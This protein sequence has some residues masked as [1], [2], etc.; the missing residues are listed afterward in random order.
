MKKRVGEETKQRISKSK[1]CR[2]CYALALYFLILSFFLTACN[3]TPPSSSSN[4]VFIKVAGS[5][6]MRPLLVQLTNA[7]SADHPNIRFDVQG[8]GSQLGQQLVE[9]GQVEV[10]MVAGPILNS[11]KD[12]RLTPIA[13]DSIAIIVNS[14]NLLVELSLRELRDIFRGHILNWQEVDGLAASIQVVSREDGS[15]TRAVF[16]RAVM[17][18]H[19]VTPTAIVM[20]SSQAVVNFVAENPNAIGYVSAAFVDGPVYAV[21][22]DGITPTLENLQSGGYFLSRDL[23]LMTSAKITPEINQFLEF[24]LSPDGQEIMAKTWGGVK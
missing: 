17:D 18:D 20:P 15:G 24:I 14:E 13:R 11:G 22:V 21:P 8:G 5:T 19:A 6:S 12:I 10:G 9:A 23:M 7:Y 16:E 1:S 3:T 4:R 2:V